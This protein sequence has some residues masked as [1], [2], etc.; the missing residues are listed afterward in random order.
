MGMTVTFCLDFTCGKSSNGS[1]SRIFELGDSE[2]REYFI[3]GWAFT[4]SSV[5]LRCKIIVELI[6]PVEVFLKCCPAQSGRRQPLGEVGREGGAPFEGIGAGADP[7]DG[8][9]EGVAGQ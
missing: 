5:F 8:G 4:I 3:L 2:V 1:C 9:V 7:E 6:G